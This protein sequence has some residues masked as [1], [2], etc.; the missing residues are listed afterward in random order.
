MFLALN[1]LTST[2]LSSI[3]L[4]HLRPA[5]QLIL[6]LLMQLGSAVV[7]S[8]V[9]VVLRLRAL[10]RA[11]PRCD[12]PR[13]LAAYPSPSDFLAFFSPSQK[14]EMMEW[15]SAYMAQQ[16]ERGALRALNP[17]RRDTPTEVLIRRR[18]DA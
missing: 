6:G 5:S 15:G 4:D 13:M 11:L 16:D 3:A 12:D 9:P 1:C 10:E 2:G 7:L 8:L 17:L 18:G 14:C